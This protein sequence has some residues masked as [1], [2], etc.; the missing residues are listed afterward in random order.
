MT[1]FYKNNNRVASQHVIQNRCL[2]LHLIYLRA[3][4]STK[5]NNLG[6]I[7]SPYPSGNASI[8]FVY[9][10]SL[11]AD[12]ALSHIFSIRWLYLSFT[13]AFFKLFMIAQCSIESVSNVLQKSIMVKQI[14]YKWYY[15]SFCISSLIVRR[16]SHTLQFLLNATCSTGWQT[17][18]LFV[19][20]SV[21]LREV[22]DSESKLTGL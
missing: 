20:L 21:F 11:K 13:R 8:L 2:S 16:W 1:T 15:V 22:S 3:S 9:W 19:T 5:I 7:M 4:S 14:L 17:S 12:I 18:N 6:E 10:C